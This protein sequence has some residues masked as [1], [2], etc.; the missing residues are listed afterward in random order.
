MPDESPALTIHLEG[1]SDVGKLRPNNEDY[2]GASP[3]SLTFAVAD[4][5]G[6]RR[7]GDIASRTAVE[8]FLAAVGR[9]G[10]DPDS[11]LRAAV[12]EANAALTW[13]MPSQP[14]SGDMSTTLL[15]AIVKGDQLY[16]ANV[17]DSRA[18]LLRGGTLQ[19]LTRDHS[20]ASEDEEMARGDPNS[21]LNR[22]F[23]SVIT[24]ALGKG[25]TSEPDI[26]T[27]ALSPGDRVILAT[28][29][30]TRQVDDD[31]IKRLAARGSTRKAIQDLI[32]RA[33]AAGGKDNVTVVIAEIDSEAA[34]TQTMP[35]TG[36]PVGA[37]AA[38]PGR[39]G[40][41]L[42]PRSTLS[43]RGPL[44]PNVLLAGAGVLGLVLLCLAFGAGVLFG[45]STG[46][47]GQP[48][49]VAQPAA[50]AGAQPTRPPGTP[51]TTGTAAAPAAAGTP[52]STAGIKTEFPN[53]TGGFEPREGDQEATPD[54]YT[55]R[56]TAGATWAFL[57]NQTPADFTVETDCKQTKAVDEATCGLVFR[58]QDDANWYKVAV[59]AQA[60]RVIVNSL[61]KGARKDLVNRANVAA[62]NKGTGTN[63][64]KVVASGTSFAI[65]VNGQ[66]IETVRD[67]TFSKGQIG[68]IA[69][70]GA[71][72]A[73]LRFTRFELTSKS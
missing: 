23:A 2:W 27:V 11:L 17:G 64:I 47:G 7:N 35:A 63:T 48:A 51:A 56:A 62:V 58:A 50:T 22:R 16:L 28:D 54:G 19:Q 72:P 45:R 36:A 12:A 42:Y 8:T 34:R 6:G 53:T 52:T 38:T 67:E 61:I 69:N 49:T 26:Y 40:G 14:G 18:Y 5:V 20:W 39:P 70:G 33:N 29:G 21:S 60:Q 46:G 66:E 41:S 1:L 15:G 32:D 73:E 9:G 57:A 24:R 13:S 59:D 55:M 30:L 31:T 65:S 71:V 4:G 10:G 44:P 37:G 43:T 3:D 25:A 68:L